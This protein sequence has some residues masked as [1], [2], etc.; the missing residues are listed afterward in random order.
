ML[1]LLL[2]TLLV[3]PTWLWS[4]P[5][6]G[7]SGFATSQPVV[8]CC[9]PDACLCNCGCD[10]DLNDTPGT[11]TP[12]DRLP[13]TRPNESK[14]AARE[15]HRPTFELIRDDSRDALSSSSAELA[16]IAGVIR[17]NRSVLCVRTT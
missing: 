3:L 7:S 4:A 9:G 16:E 10:A 14:S 15:P 8:S 17:P 2:I 1:R 13:T 5:A 12:D 6:S 11:P